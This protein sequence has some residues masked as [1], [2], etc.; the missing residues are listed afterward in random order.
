VS[1]VVH[2]KHSHGCGCFS[3]IGLFLG[4]LVLIALFTKG[5]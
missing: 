3:G 2:H 5:C 1:T 4:A